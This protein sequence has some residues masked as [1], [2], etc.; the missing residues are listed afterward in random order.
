MLRSAFILISLAAVGCASAPR[1]GTQGSA[2]PTVQ[3]GDATAAALGIDP[4]L[5]ANEVHP[6]LARAGREPSAYLGYQDTT[7][8]AATIY[9]DNLENSPYGDV[10]QRESVTVKSKSRYR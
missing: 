10:Y 3:Y 9:T 7:T 4:P 1:P 2:V 8:E 5:T 6:E